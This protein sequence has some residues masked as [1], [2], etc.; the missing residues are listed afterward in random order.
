[1][2]LRKDGVPIGDRLQIS[3]RAQL[4]LGL[5]GA[6]RDHRAAERLRRALGHRPGRGQMVGE[7][8]VDEV[9]G[10]EAGGVEGARHAEEIGASGLQLVN[11]PGRGENP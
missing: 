4:L 3:D 1:M 7:G 8:I 2:I 11:R 9:A 5:A 6:G 10:A